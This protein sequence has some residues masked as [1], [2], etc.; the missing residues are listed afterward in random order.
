MSLIYITFALNDL[1]IATSRGCSL[2]V[3][4][5]GIIAMLVFCSMR[6]CFAES[7]I[8]AEK[9]SITNNDCGFENG[10]R[11]V[12]IFSIHHTISISFIHPLG[13]AHT[14]TLEGKLICGT[15]LSLKIINGGSFVPSAIHARTT[16]KCDLS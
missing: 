15:F 4:P 5:P 10:E 6:C 1:F 3:K 7:V 2:P 11:I 13:F 8:C 16:V 14:N 9:E 12:Q